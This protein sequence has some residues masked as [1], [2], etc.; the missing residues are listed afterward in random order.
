MI[1]FLS[2]SSYCIIEKGGH[3]TFAKFEEKFTE[4]REKSVRCKG[5]VKQRRDPLLTCPR[6][7]DD[8]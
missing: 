3:V 8:E 6:E 1:F 2:A 4:W 5:G 7:Q